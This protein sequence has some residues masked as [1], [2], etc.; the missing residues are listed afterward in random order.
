MESKNKFGIILSI[1]ILLTIIIGGFILMKKSENFVTKKNTT[2]TI[3]QEKKD[4][5]INKDQDYI[6]YENKETITDELDIEY[7][8]VVI[9]FEDTNHIMDKLNNETKELKKKL[10]YDNNLQDAA[11][12][13]LSYAEYKKYTIYNFD[14]YVSLL[15][16]YYAFD[17]ENIV[18][19]Q[20]SAS[21]VFDKET[22]HLYSNQ[23]LLKNFKL[24]DVDLKEKV[25]TYLNDQ[26]LV[27]NNTN[28][29]VKDTVA[30]A[31]DY[32]LYVDKIGHLQASILVK[33]S[34]NDYNEVILIN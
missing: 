29:L 4:I 1:I 3:K 17:P 23:E 22:G 25:E 32:A 10:T 24:T 8:D 26:N 7:K 33:S 5:R 30:M 21:Y 20:K 14:K 13:N 16:D 11:Y 19:Y 12:N 15:V 27:N 2:N 34:E 9:N 31:N 18:K 6:Y 28:I